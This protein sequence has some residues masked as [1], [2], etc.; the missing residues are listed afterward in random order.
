M[1]G[2]ADTDVHDCTKRSNFTK[3]LNGNFKITI[4][5]QQILYLTP[6]LLVNK[7]L[8]LCAP[9]P[10]KWN[11][12]TNHYQT[13]QLQLIKKTSCV[14]DKQQNVGYVVLHD[15]NPSSFGFT[16]QDVLH[17]R[18]PQVLIALLRSA[19][20]MPVSLNIIW[21]KVILWQ[22]IG[23]FFFHRRSKEMISPCL[24]AVS[25]K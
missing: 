20:P 10:V 1:A 14:N 2:G 3:Q 7:S 25:N 9:P 4:T 21:G 18:F 11:N 24:Q 6:S 23:M 13:V 5:M 17:K 16:G 15:Q 12:T 8:Y 19:T 22:W